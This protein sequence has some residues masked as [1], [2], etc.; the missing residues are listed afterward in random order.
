MKERWDTLLKGF[1]NEQ[2]D[3]FDTTKIPD[4]YDCIKYDALHNRDFLKNI[5]STYR[6]VKQLADFVI[7]Q[8]YG[9]LRKEKLEIGKSIVREL[10]NRCI[11]NLEGGLVDS[12]APASRV[13]LYFSSESHLHSLR[14]TLLLS[15]VPHNSNVA[16][17]LESCEINY[18]SH[19]VFRLF[20]DL[21]KDPSDP[22]RFYV[23]IQFSPGAAQDPFIFVE[24]GHL[25]PVS[26]PIPI[27]GRVPFQKFKEMFW[28]PKNQPTPTAAAP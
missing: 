17:A 2:T 26:R 14:N 18:L 11:S 7:P 24:S 13:S 19:C 15:G 21:S 22:L 9:V 27:N 16:T 6:A 3:E 5:R 20:E 23:N 25:L 4:I 28:R 8:Q 1:Y 10:L 12:P